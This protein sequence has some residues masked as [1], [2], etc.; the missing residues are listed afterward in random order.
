MLARV[1]VGNDND[2][3]GDL[4]A[5]HPLVQL[6]HDLL[7]VCA[8]LVVGRDEHIQAIFLDGGEVFGW[9]DASL[10]T[11]CDRSVHWDL[12]VD[13]GREGWHTEW[14]GWSIETVKVVPLLVMRFHRQKSQGAAN[15]LQ[16]R[17]R[18]LRFP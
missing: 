16:T 18:A 15:D 10:E 13:R 8:D 12:E 9:V 4:A 11:G 1:L 14:C 7:D 3:L 5:H 2:Q 17:Q 6:G